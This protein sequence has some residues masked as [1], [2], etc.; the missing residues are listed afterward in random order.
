[1]VKPIVKVLAPEDIP[2]MQALRREALASAP[3][4]FASS[5]DD[6]RTLDPGFVAR[7]IANAATS[8]IL[9]ALADGRAVGMVGAARQEKRKSQHRAQI[10]GMYVSPEWRRGGVGAQLLAAVLEH[11]RAWAG[12]R[13][14]ALC[15][16]SAARD[17]QRL[18]ERAGF[19]VWGCEPAAL[20]WKD[21]SVDDYHLIL[22]VGD[23]DVDADAD[24]RSVR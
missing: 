24:K 1:M 14:V 4:A 2:L 9:L 12:V 13:E 11:I 10:W 18:Y 17:A 22:P 7:S 15:V 19:R 23:A 8:V 21:V 3:Y 5:L 20:R 6:D 16:T